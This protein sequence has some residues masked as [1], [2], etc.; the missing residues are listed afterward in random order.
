MWCGHLIYELRHGDD[1]CGGAG[2]N[3]EVL[4][5]WFPWVVVRLPGGAVRAGCA[6]GVDLDSSVVLLLVLLLELG[7][8]P[9]PRGL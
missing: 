4:G 6:G 9:L 2:G 3:E 8:E 1:V 5:V 7:L